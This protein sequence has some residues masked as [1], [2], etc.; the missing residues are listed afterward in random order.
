[1]K[2]RSGKLTTITKKSTTKKK[3]QKSNRSKNNASDLNLNAQLPHGSMNRNN[4]DQQQFQETEEPS[5]NQNTNFEELNERTT[6]NVR[7]NVE[8]ERENEQLIEHGPQNQ[9]DDDS[10][11]A[12][13]NNNNNTQPTDVSSEEPQNNT[14]QEIH[15]KPRKKM[16][17]FIARPDK[18][19]LTG[20]LAENWK[21]F[22]RS[23][24]NFLV[25]AE[26]NTK[27][28]AVK[29]AIFLNTLGEEGNDVFDAFGLTAEQKAVYATVIQTFENFCKPKTNEVYER[30]VF[31]QRNQKEGEPFDTFLMEIRR[32]VR[33]CE[34]GE[35][36]QTMLKYRIQ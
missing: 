32:L 10:D 36:E 7:I 6:N 15:S 5:V 8:A 20:N 4:N 27:P 13:Q 21:R 12:Q 11:S 35:M 23:F 24:D 18:L 2:L 28:D 19:K 14:I 31:Y 9:S 26:C 34:F 3:N 33:T 1:M 16:S 29:T 25:A 22:K 30:F 17:D